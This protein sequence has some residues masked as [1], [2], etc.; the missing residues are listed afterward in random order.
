MKM[1]IYYYIYF[2]T[3]LTCYNSYNSGDL[4]LVKY[5]YSNIIHF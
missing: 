5:K 2:W 3:L 1:G 4:G